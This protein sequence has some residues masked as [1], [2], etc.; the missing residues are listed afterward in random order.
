MHNPL[1]T[2]KGCAQ[3]DQNPSSVSLNLYSQV[4]WPIASCRLYIQV[5]LADKILK[6]T[7]SCSEQA[8]ALT[9]A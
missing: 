2:V 4:S 7:E 3:S 8:L 6:L 5:V 9:L 1:A